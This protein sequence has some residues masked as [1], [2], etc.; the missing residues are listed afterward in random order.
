VQLQLINR[1]FI[2][3]DRGLYIHVIVRTRDTALT[4]Q[5]T[6]DGRTVYARPRTNPRY[7]TRPSCSCRCIAREY[8]QAASTP[9]TTAVG[10]PCRTSRRDAE[11]VGSRL[12]RGLEHERAASAPLLRRSR[13][14]AARVVGARRPHQSRTYRWRRS[15]RADGTVPSHLHAGDGAPH[16]WINGYG[17]GGSFELNRD[18]PCWLLV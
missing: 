11:T 15:G 2:G 16:Y 10:L 14:P 4:S 6:R 5:T 12:A 3:S 7:T 8:V 1:F 17:G 13:P 9:P 18:M